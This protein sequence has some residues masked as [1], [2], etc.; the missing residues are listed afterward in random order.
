MINWELI[1]WEMI[2]IIVELMQWFVIL[3]IWVIL[4]K[5]K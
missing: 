5:P 1:E 3:W 2:D 4:A